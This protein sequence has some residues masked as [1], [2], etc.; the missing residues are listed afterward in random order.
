MRPGLGRQQGHVVEMFKIV[1][2]GVLKLPEIP[3]CVVAVELMPDGAVAGAFGNIKSLNVVTIDIQF[4]GAV[5]LPPFLR[6]AFVEWL[7]SLVSDG[8]KDPFGTLVQMAVQIVL[9]RKLL[10]L[11]GKLDDMRVLQGLVPG[12]RL[13]RKEL[14]L[15]FQRKTGIDKIL[16]PDRIADILLRH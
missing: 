16:D 6:R 1:M 12:E 13:Q 3:E 5:D 10:R 7:A 2:S 8:A 15:Q 4:D 14:L 11:R 9:P